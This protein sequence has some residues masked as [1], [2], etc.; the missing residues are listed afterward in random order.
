[1]ALGV[2]ALLAIAACWRPLAPTAPLR[3]RIVATL[4]LGSGVLVTGLLASLRGRGTA[5]QLALYAFLVLG[6]DGLGQWGSPG[7]GRCGR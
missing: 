6:L 7:A 5:E 4:I 3:L 1:M 2:A